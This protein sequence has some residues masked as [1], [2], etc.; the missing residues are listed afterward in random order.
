MPRFFSFST[1]GAWLALA[2][3]TICP[4]QLQF[5]R[6]VRWSATAAKAGPETGDRV[7]AKAESRRQA[8]L[9][10]PAPS[11]AEIRERGQKLIQ[12]QHLDDAALEQYERIEHQVNRS[13]G[14]SPRILEDKLYRV[15][16]TGTGTL[17]ILLK[18]D[19]QAAD[20]VLYRQQ[21]RTWKELLE[22]AVKPDDPRAKLAYSKW[23]KRRPI[24]QN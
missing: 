5:E 11:D 1:V 17:K 4:A 9:Q 13:A 24:A 6:A 16:P 14:A 10:S 3:L 21:L 18:E 8:S 22:L 2:G 19:N 12:N 7:P 15:V 23:R 20:P